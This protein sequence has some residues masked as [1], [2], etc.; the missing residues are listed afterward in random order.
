[1]ANNTYLMQVHNIC[2]IKLRHYPRKYPIPKF[3]TR[4]PFKRNPIDLT[5]ADSDKLHQWLYKQFPTSYISEENYRK[6][7]ITSVLTVAYLYPLCHLKDRYYHILQHMIYFFIMDDNT[8]EPWG[9]LNS[10][11]NMA[12]CRRVW[13]QVKTLVANISGHQISS[14]SPVVDDDDGRMEPY[15]RIIRPTFTNIF[16]SLNGQQWLRFADSWLDYCTANVEEN[17]TKGQQ[18]FV[19]VNQVLILRR[20]TI[21]LIPTVLSLEYAYNIEIHESEWLDPRMQL[22]LQ[23]LNDHI[24]YINDLFS[25]EKELKSNIIVKSNTMGTGSHQSLD[26]DRQVL[27]QMANTV[28][29][30]AVELNCSIP[31]AQTVICKRIEQLEIEMIKLVVDWEQSSVND[32]QSLS[33]GVRQFIS[34]QL[35]MP[36]GNYRSSLGVDRYNKF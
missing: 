5:V 17:Q 2:D 30:T 19:S 26:D 16:Q 24:I 7:A 8:E 3:K 32:G 21:G 9:R 10:M 29:Q 12:E 4:F 35:Y 34:G 20:K 23:L 15:V 11:D 28:A 6:L 31:D 13:A 1:M 33:P 27:P 25:F 18:R 14:S 22:L 36:G